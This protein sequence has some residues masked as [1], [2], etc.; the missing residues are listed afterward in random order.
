MGQAMSEQEDRD[1]YESLRPESPTPDD[2]LCQCDDRPPIVLQDH[3]SSNPFACLKCNLEVPPERIGFTA[4][5]AGHI[6]F[7]WNLYRALYTLWLDSEDYEA[8]ATTQLEDPAGRV[9]VKGLELVEDLNKYRRAYYRWF[10]DQ[11]VDNFVPLT[12]C[13]RCSAELVAAVGTLGPSWVCDK[14]SIALWKD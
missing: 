3:L 11:S 7:W 10:Q 4:E 2:D 9:N 1:P 12:Q 8:W 6:A 5:L 13:P 14:C